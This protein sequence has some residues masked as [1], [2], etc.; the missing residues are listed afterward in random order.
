[1]GGSSDLHVCS[2]EGL[3]SNGGVLVEG[4][5]E[6]VRAL[7]KT[8]SLEGVKLPKDIALWFKTRRGNRGVRVSGINS[9]LT[10]GR[11]WFERGLWGSWISAK[12][13]ELTP[14]SS[15][16]RRDARILGGAGRGGW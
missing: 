6:E 2:K 4:T 5:V 15:V 16:F 3:K 10:K 8:H 11:P 7:G 13:L 14:G 9:A 1:M 12:I